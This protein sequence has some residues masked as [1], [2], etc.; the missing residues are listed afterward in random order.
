MP[1]MRKKTVYKR[2]SLSDFFIGEPPVKMCNYLKKIDYIK[3]NRE[4]FHKCPQNVS[5]V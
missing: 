3:F 4:M 2:N 1:A 5:G